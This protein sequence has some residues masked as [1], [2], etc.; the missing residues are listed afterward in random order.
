MDARADAGVN[1]AGK[2]TDGACIGLAGFLHW[3]GLV[4]DRHAERP[5]TPQP[6]PWPAGQPA[7]PRGDRSPIA[8]LWSVTGAHE[9]SFQNGHP[10]GAWP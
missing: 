8:C 7:S 1:D 9:L 4:S 6:G 3:S 2:P 5:E 10:G